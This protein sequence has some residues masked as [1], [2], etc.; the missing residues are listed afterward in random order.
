M[1][2]PTTPSLRRQ[3]TTSKNNEEVIFNAVGVRTADHDGPEV[4]TR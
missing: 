3:K 4:W 1:F 2:R